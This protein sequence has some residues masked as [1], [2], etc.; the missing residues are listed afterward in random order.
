MIL[1]TLPN[2]IF[3]LKSKNRILYVKGSFVVPARSYQSLGTLSIYFCRPTHWS[4][5]FP[6]IFKWRQKYLNFYQPIKSNRQWSFFRLIFY[7]SFDHTHNFEKNPYIKSIEW[8]LN[9]LIII[10][11]VFARWQILQ[12]KTSTKTHLSSNSQLSNTDHLFIPVGL[13]TKLFFRFIYFRLFSLLF[14]RS[15]SCLGVYE[16]N[17]L[18]L[19]VLVGCFI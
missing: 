9:R 5:W 13:L 6:C 10:Y 15:L 12:K 1:L 7:F 3:N 19:R 4:I 2:N 18:E 11:V 17:G 16:W 14:S 8:A